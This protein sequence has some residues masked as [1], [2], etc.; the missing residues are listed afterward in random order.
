MLFREEGVWS[1]EEGLVLP[2]VVYLGAR[3]YIPHQQQE[4]DGEDQLGVA[5]P[6]E[7]RWWDSCGFVQ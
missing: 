7:Y 3:Q 4:E 2:T 6:M 1:Q 5:G